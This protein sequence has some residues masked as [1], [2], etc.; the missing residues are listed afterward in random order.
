VLKSWSS[1]VVAFSLFG[2]LYATPTLPISTFDSSLAPESGQMLG[3]ALASP[4]VLWGL[5][6]NLATHLTLLLGLYASLTVLARRWAPRAG[7]RQALAWPSTLA[8]GWVWLVTGNG[9]L[10][11]HSQ[12]SG[13]FLTLAPY[14]VGFAVA[15][16]GLAS[17]ALL[18]RPLSWSLPSQ[19]LGASSLVAALAFFAFA[20]MEAPLLHAQPVGQRNIIIIGIDSLS[21]PLLARESHYLPRLSALQAQGRRH[22]RA[23]TPIGRTFPAWVDI[24]SGRSTSE[25]GALFNL[26]GIEHV[27]RDDLLGGSL[28]S[29]GYRTVYA[30]DERRFNNIDET[31]GFDSVVGPK[32]GVL[33]FV[34]QRFNDTPL[35]NL[36]LQARAAKWLLPYSRLNAASAANYDAKGFV[37]EIER[38]IDSPM[39]VFLAV[40]FLS[41]HYPFATRHATQAYPTRTNVFRA[42]H[43]EA[44]TTVDM[45]VGRLM[46]VLRAK[47][48]LEDTLVILLSDHGEALGENEPVLQTN[49][50]LKARVS[51]GHGADLLS[52]HQN[53]IVLTVL[54]YLHGEPDPASQGTSESM[55][56]LLDVRPAV[57]RFLHSGQARLEPG[58][59]CI[60]VETELRLAAA[61]DYRHLEPGRVAA[62]G[63]GLYEID[64]QGRLRLR[65]ST[66][67]GL[68]AHKDIGLR[69]A[70]RLTVYTPAD[71]RYRAYRLADGKPSEETNARADDVERIR[72]YR[73]RLLAR[74]ERDAAEASAGTVE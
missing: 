17:M 66:L 10:F 3:L 23:Y 25:H 51:Y 24:L 8:V 44:L 64:E 60:D 39:P 69:C 21:A 47:G 18:A 58:A 67:A 27:D 45:Q 28:A 26:R 50:K 38:A 5:A 42:H 40:H 15:S 19:A 56:S 6:T 29:H 37:D 57:E 32:E 33:D 55:V 34:L 46:D 63:A 43:V 9:L 20:T 59:E 13:W 65:E 72:L 74:A 35:T 12:Y 30:I 31:F 2:L 62:E 52:E 61:S 11:E 16:T 7:V 22:E 68:A 53:R 41:G 1:H 54:H 49:G 36:L 71:G 14:D 73:D 4:P 48:R 70:D